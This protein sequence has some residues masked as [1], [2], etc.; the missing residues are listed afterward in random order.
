MTESRSHSFSSGVFSLHWF[1]R[2]EY[3]KSFPLTLPGESLI[4]ITGHFFLPTPLNQA[5]LQPGFSKEVTSREWL[6]IQRC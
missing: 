4:R 2:W 5:G 3:D 1:A 6:K